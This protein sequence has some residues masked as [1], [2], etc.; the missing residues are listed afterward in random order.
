MTHRI[1]AMPRGFHRSVYWQIADVIG[2]RIV[3]GEYPPGSVLPTED[4]FSNVLAVSRTAFREAMKMLAGKG[5]VESR[6]KTGTRVR[7]RHQ[8]NM[9][10]PDVTAW[11][12]MAGPERGHG[13][14][15]FEL[16]RII[17]PAASAL[18]AERR[19]EANLE[20]MREALAGMAAAT[21]RDEWIGPDLRFHNEILNSTGNELLISLG[22]LIEP[23]LTFTFAFVNVDKR[24]RRASVPLH[25]AVFHGIE[26]GDSEA[27]RRAM[28]KLLD[29]ALI[30]L[31]EMLEIHSKNAV[32]TPS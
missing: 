3:A 2:Q 1:D 8:W 17:E 24:R 27:A 4:T 23:A 19:G 32:V 11:A 10:D 5:L 21:N 12:F 25:A 31:E 29:D 26:A 9:L 6:P 7:E 14:A 18:S 13:R 20:R 22:R 30:D 15:L 16:R 28:T